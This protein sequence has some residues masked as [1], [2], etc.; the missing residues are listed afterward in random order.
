M[1][2]GKRVKGTK[3]TARQGYWLAIYEGV[4]ITDHFIF[5][6][7]INGYNVGIYRDAA[8]LPP[9]IAAVIAFG[10]GIMGAVLGMSQVWF[11]GPIGAKIGVPP[12]GGD[13]GFELAF[14]FAMTSY[15]P[16][17]IVE[18]RIFGR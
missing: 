2:P 12:F 9:G 17:R 13:I 1:S 5:K 10:F 16:L 18:R 15:I 4:S 6:R 8:L 7:G 3:L 14:L 11:V